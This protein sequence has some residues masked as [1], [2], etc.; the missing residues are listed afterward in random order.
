MSPLIWRAMLVLALGGAW[1]LMP[2]QASAR[3]EFEVCCGYGEYDECSS[4]MLNEVCDEGPEG[5]FGGLCS[6]EPHEDCDNEG[7]YFACTY[8]C[9]GET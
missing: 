9:G 7:T 5:Q 1:A 8:G 4:E 3:G 6:H 2:A